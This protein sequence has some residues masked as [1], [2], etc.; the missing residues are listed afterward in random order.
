MD[1]RRFINFEKGCYIGQEVILR[2]DTYNKVQK[3]LMALTFSS[4]GVTK[5]DT[6]R[7]EGKNAGTITSVVEHPISGQHIGLGLVRSAFALP[8]TQLEVLNSQGSPVAQASVRDLPATPT[9][10]S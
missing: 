9:V 3:L 4:A 7:Q 8:G 2:L 10:P 1:L 6:L 5:W